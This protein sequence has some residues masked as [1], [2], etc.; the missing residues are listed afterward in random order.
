MKRESL[1][2]RLDRQERDKLE[3]IASDWGV[4]LAGAVRRLIR[5]Y[6]KEEFVIRDANNKNLLIWR[7]E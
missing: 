3:K 7:K 2:I 6:K 4:S 1:P 5:E